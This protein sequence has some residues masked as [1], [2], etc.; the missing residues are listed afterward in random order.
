MNIRLTYTLQ[1]NQ[2]LGSFSSCLT[3][4]AANL[5]WWYLSAG[6]HSQKYIMFEGCCYPNPKNPTWTVLSPYP[7]NPLAVWTKSTEVQLGNWCTIGDIVP[8]TLK[9]GQGWARYHPFVQTPR[10]H[11]KTT[12][13]GAHAWYWT[14]VRK[15][16]RLLPD[17]TRKHGFG[18]TGILRHEDAM[19]LLE[20]YIYI[21]LYELEGNPLPSMFN[22]LIQN[23]TSQAYN[24]VI[25]FKI[26][27]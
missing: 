5:S 11:E 24:C 4:N 21:D 17:A 1:I 25:W 19:D 18:H 15:P 6:T 22:P 2:L 12:A 10:K 26:I 16:T 20:L 27:C 3:R 14:Q 23:A 13:L 8:G 7:F 9:A